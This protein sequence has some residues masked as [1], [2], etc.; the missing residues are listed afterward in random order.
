MPRF[1]WPAEFGARAI[2]N[3]FGARWTGHEDELGYGT[4]AREEFVRARA[5]QDY[6]VAHIYAGQSI[7][8]LDAVR[9]AATIV[10]EIEAQARDLLDRW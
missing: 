9:P 8:M 4:E 10:M 2:R 7:G 6:D 1:P 5:A 3:A